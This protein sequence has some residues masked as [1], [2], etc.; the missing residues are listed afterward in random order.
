MKT[1]RNIARRILVDETHKRE[2]TLLERAIK[3][4]ERLRA[5]VLKEKTFVPPTREI[6]TEIKED[7]RDC[8][9]IEDKPL[10]IE[11]LPL[12]NYSSDSLEWDEQAICQSDLLLKYIIEKKFL[13]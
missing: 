12:N 8:Y 3:A 1:I 2:Q 11:K 9:T 6:Y 4:E 5:H 10:L 7:W 13:I